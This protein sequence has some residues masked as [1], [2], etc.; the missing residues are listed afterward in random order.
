M[1]SDAALFGGHPERLLVVS[2]HPGDADRALGGS[3]HGWVGRGTVAQLV[4]VTSGDA[5]GDDGGADPLRVAAEREG[6]QRA[7]SALIG[8]DDV[9][10]LHR[11]EGAVAND[12]ALREQLV[13]LIR[14]FKP[15]VIAAPDPSVLFPVSG[16]I[17][18]VDHR[19]VG[20]AA[21]DAVMPAG[22]AMAFPSLLAAADMLPHQVARLLLYWPA[23]PSDIVDI[24]AGIE[25]K[26]AAVLGYAHAGSCL[27]WSLGDDS[28]DDRAGRVRDDAAHHGAGIGTEAAEAFSLIEL[29]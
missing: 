8:Y 24:G 1:S 17:Q 28:P 26:I 9:T 13:R 6:E 14:S 25:L 20:Y 18:H 4:C 7:A 2:A 27:G 29:G 16:G 19:V 10:F 22:N 5:S 3:V 23:R 15:D 12:L 21:I 11:P